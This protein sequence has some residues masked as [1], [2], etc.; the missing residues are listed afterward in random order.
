MKKS[1]KVLVIILAIV[2]I[3]FYFK[4]LGDFEFVSFSYVL[5]VLVSYCLLV[6]TFF[7]YI[8]EE[9]YSRRQFKVK[10]LLLFAGFMVIPLCLTFLIVLFKEAGFSWTVKPLIMVRYLMLFILPLF[11]PVAFAIAN[12]TE[13]RYIPVR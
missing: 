1:L 6:W 3:P 8:K 9:N 7:D 12:A 13:T 2:S 5:Q 11:W 4:F 10:L